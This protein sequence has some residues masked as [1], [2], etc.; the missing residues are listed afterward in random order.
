MYISLTSSTV[1]H[2]IKLKISLIYCNIT[3]SKLAIRGLITI[4][5]VRHPVLMVT[6]CT[7]AIICDF[8]TRTRGRFG[9]GTFW[10]G[11]VLTWDV[12]VWGRFGLGTF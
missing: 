11:D 1:R 3:I 7:F 6:A 4:T 10:P 8:F 9:L 2:S 12:L 5:V